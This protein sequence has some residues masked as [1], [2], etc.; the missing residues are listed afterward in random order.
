M[1]IH[2]PPSPTKGAS[3]FCLLALLQLGS[4]RGEKVV[5]V[6]G[7]GKSVSETPATQCRLHALAGD[8]PVRRSA[9]T[10]C[11]IVKTDPRS[12]AF[13]T[14]LQAVQATP[15]VPEWERIAGRL[16]HHL[17]LAVRGDVTLDA[18][19]AALDADVDAILEKRR[20]LRTR[21]RG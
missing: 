21:G 6:A 9:W 16:A 7:G 20:W 1:H 17:E 2:Q 15:K 12:A 11:D 14:Q 5:V 4:A 18:A 10:A 3:L 19:L 13:W 8:L